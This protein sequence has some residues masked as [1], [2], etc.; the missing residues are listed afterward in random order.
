VLTADATACPK[1]FVSYRRTDGSTAG[2]LSDWLKR[3]FK[4]LC[5]DAV[6][7][8]IEDIE[9]GDAFP[10]RVD[11]A[12]RSAAVAI[13]V[14]GRGWV[15]ELN[16]R[17]AAGKVDHVRREVELALELRRKNG[18]L[19]VPV[20]IH[21]AEMTQLANL[22]PE[23]QPP[24]EDLSSLHA[25]ELRAG[26]HWTADC[27]DL[28]GMIGRRL[29]TPKKQ[30][31]AQNA[32]AETER[33][34]ARL[35]AELRRWVRETLDDA[36]LAE[37]RLFKPLNL[38]DSIARNSML[39]N[40][41]TTYRSGRENTLIVIGEEGTGKTVAVA[42]WLRQRI[43][44]LVQCVLYTSAQESHG[45][46]REPMEFL[47]HGLLQRAGGIAMQL[48][49]L[50]RDNGFQD[51]IAA[52][53]WLVIVD[54]INE[55]G[56]ADEW[57]RRISGFGALST[58]G[59][60]ALFTTRTEHLQRQLQSYCKHAETVTIG[61]FSTAEL[62]TLLHR[63]GLELEDIP[64]EARPLL[65]R[66][67]YFQRALKHRHALA[68]LRNISIPQ[69]IFLD[70][71]ERTG[72]RS[73]AL[74]SSPDFERLLL[75]Y[76]KSAR[77]LRAAAL[78]RTA[79][80]DSF[81]TDDESAFTRKLDELLQQRVLR[82]NTAGM[83]E[84]N[85]ELLPIALGL[86]MLEKLIERPGKDRVALREV[87]AGW[88]GDQQDDL[89]ADICEA[90]TTAALSR[91]G[92]A[93]EVTIVLLE[94]WLTSQN[95]HERSVLRPPRA[96]PLASIRR[97]YTTAATEILELIEWMLAEG[98]AARLLGDFA[99]L[100]IDIAQNSQ[101]DPVPIVDALH[102]WLGLHSLPEAPIDNE[103]NR[104]AYALR[105]RQ[106]HQFDAGV[107]QVPAQRANCR[108][109]ALAVL[110]QVHELLSTAQLR[111]AIVSVA[112]D[113]LTAAFDRLCWL[114]RVIR[115]DCLAEI[116]QLFDDCHALPALQK[117]VG[118]IAWYAWP[119]SQANAWF[120]RPE[121]FSGQAW[122]LDLRDELLHAA[123]NEAAI[124][125]LRAAPER[126]DIATTYYIRDEIE[127]ALALYQP[128]LFDALQ[129]RVL[130]LALDDPTNQSGSLALWVAR[131]APLLTAVQA[132]RVRI[133]ARRRR[134][135]ADNMPRGTIELSIA[136]NWQRP[137]LVRAAY[138]TRFAAAGQAMDDEIAAA[139]LDLTGRH[140]L[141]RRILRSTRPDATDALF[142]I[143]MRTD[144]PSGHDVSQLLQWLRH[145]DL[146]AF[147]E[148]KRVNAIQ[149][150][151]IHGHCGDA[152][153]LVPPRW[154]YESGGAQA[155]N[156]SR[157]LA[158][159]GQL[160]LT[161]ARQRLSTND[162]PLWA[163]HSRA[164]DEEWRRIGRLIDALLDEDDPLHQPLPIVSA[165]INMD[166]QTQ[167]D[168]DWVHQEL[169]Q[170]REAREIEL[171]ARGEWRPRELRAHLSECV[172]RF[173]S[174]GTAAF[175]R[176]TGFL[177]AITG[178]AA[179]FGDK[180]AL[181]LIRALWAAENANG[182]T[183]S[184][185]HAR[186]VVLW[187]FRLSDS[188]DARALWDE[189]A[190]ELRTDDEL[191]RF[192]ACAQI[193][194]GEAWLRDRIS[195]RLGSPLP[196]HEVE[197]AVLAGAAGFADVMREVRARIDTAHGWRETGFKFALDLARDLRDARAW[198]RRFRTATRWTTAYGAFKAYLRLV[199]A[200]L[201]I[202][203]ETRAYDHRDDPDIGQARYHYTWR[204]D[205]EEAIKKRHTALKKTLF[206]ETLPTPH[207]GRWAHMRKLL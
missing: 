44:T 101:N 139:D 8:D 61:D 25:T 32:E 38:A 141:V 202:F 131:A 88:L 133:E 184:G 29:D 53:S 93:P 22:V 7:F 92:V 75:Y 171:V 207:L 21:G 17:L 140:L 114:M 20:L 96:S 57:G 97:L 135:A 30:S 2:R 39:A 172:E 74:L 146:D 176:A 51:W 164:T 34:L 155:D 179:Y 132:R 81:S 80:R 113:G 10:S 102:K 31:P 123:P 55:D 68:G 43:D 19:V 115:S 162:L 1:I 82:N 200:R 45:W 201:T 197:A 177:H 186:D 104:T 181:F 143:L 105:E 129:E 169:Q 196:G 64:A 159:S 18:I 137:S 117:A 165:S 153:R 163:A 42:Q 175:R 174:R 86:L 4:D 14:I 33:L 28:L 138:I 127:F 205:V 87:A 161:Q 36:D 65:H 128:E 15:D 54:G 148:N 167:S 157:A 100:L 108:I 56:S 199:D 106:A 46:P 198:Y 49:V 77:D 122:Y 151:I 59:I 60:M 121:S 24:M 149:W 35:D 84:V 69:L 173:C 187:G 119:V 125:V 76:A 142:Y 144:A 183:R 170:L 130:Q 11:G 194:N 58:P 94:R 160:T 124:A 66:P 156:W 9:P 79:L 72:D 206:G 136:G 185:N 180:N 120:V 95:A 99:E 90:A 37:R 6:F 47:R 189:M 41:E 70:W 67:R 111:R 118:N 145:I 168:D 193:G 26:Q 40:I 23:L 52:R 109:L 83:L 147:D 112:V 154:E 73:G 16:S 63:N 152:A 103:K 158:W 116:Q 48:D 3:R 50:R 191:I 188:S 203:G 98:H 85:E 13:I 190:D 134:R 89:R 91:L 178:S 110:S 150:L 107:I 27:N 192:V 182:R 62:K 195:A 166:V 12:L 204:S 126:D 5:K 71:R 78:G